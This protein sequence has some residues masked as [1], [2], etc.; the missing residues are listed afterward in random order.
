[1]YTFIKVINKNKIKRNSE[2]KPTKTTNRL[3]FT[4]LKIFL[5]IFNIYF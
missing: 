1:M 4:G 3:I 5:L 2:K